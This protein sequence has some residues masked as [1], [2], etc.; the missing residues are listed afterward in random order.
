M[1]TIAEH[2]EQQIHKILCYLLDK[3]EGFQKKYLFYYNE[4]RYVVEIRKFKKK[5]SVD[6]NAVLQM[7][8]TYLSNK[9]GQPKENIYRFY[10]SKFSEWEAKDVKG[11]GTY[12][13]PRP[14]K[15]YN[16]S[17]FCEY[18][19]KVRVDINDRFGEWLPMPGEDNWDYFFHTY[20]QK[21]N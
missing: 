11:F 3:I 15:T 9:T 13:L 12:Y 18:I 14:V 5:R 4:V 10:E 8:F 7:L 6:Q 2:P 16:T 17:E 19:E 21:G 20:K 1:K